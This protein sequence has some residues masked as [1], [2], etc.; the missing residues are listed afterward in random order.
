MVPALLACCCVVARAE[1]PRVSL[2][3][4]LANPHNYGMADLHLHQFGEFK[5]GGGLFGGRSYGDP[6][7]ALGECDGT[8]EQLVQ[9]GA[10][11]PPL[12]GPFGAVTNQIDALSPSQRALVEATLAMVLRENHGDDLGP[13]HRPGL[14]ADPTRRN[15]TGWPTS[16]SIAHTQTWTGWLRLAHEGPAFV[17][18]V[19]DHF[20][21]PT[22]NIVG[23]DLQA[24]L[25][26][27]LVDFRGPGYA[28]NLAAARAD[29]FVGLD[30]IV[31]SAVHIR[32][33]CNVVFEPTLRARAAPQV[34]NGHSVTA[35]EGGT[36]PA[37]ER[38]VESSPPSSWTFCDD[39]RAVPAI[40]RH[41]T[42]WARQQRDW[43]A[44][45]TS[46]EEAWEIIQ[47]GRLAV[48][49]SM[50]VEDVLADP[51]EEPEDLLDDVFGEGLRTLTIAH[52]I[53]SRYA[54][55]A[56]WSPALIG[57]LQGLREDYPY[58]IDPSVPRYPHKRE[59]RLNSFERSVHRALRNNL[60]DLLLL[61]FRVSKVASFRDR[62][63][64]MS[65]FTDVAHYAM[66]DGVPVGPP[67]NSV[68]LTPDGRNLIMQMVRR[69]MPIDV[70]HLSRAAVREIDLLL[71]QRVD[72][73]DDRFPLYASHAHVA[74]LEVDAHTDY[75]LSSDVLEIL[76]RR[77]GVVGLRPSDDLLHG[78]D[79]PFARAL[80]DFDCRRTSVS[81]AAS[82]H[83][84]QRDFGQT[85]EAPGIRLAWGTDLT[86]FI[87]MASRL[88]G[89]LPGSAQPRTPQ[90]AAAVRERLRQRGEPWAFC[91][92]AGVS[93]LP[94]SEF[95]GR[96]LAHVGLVPGMMDEVE[97]LL[98]V[99]ETGR[100]AAAG[101][102]RGAWSF[103]ELWYRARTFADG[104]PVRAAHVPSPL[105]PAEPRD[106]Y[107]RPVTELPVARYVGDRSARPI[108]TTLL[109]AIE[110][111]LPYADAPLP[112]VVSDAPVRDRSFA[113]QPPT[114]AAQLLMTGYRLED[115]AAWRHDVERYV[116]AIG[117]PAAQ[118]PHEV[119][120]AAGELFQSILRACP[121]AT[122]AC[123][124]SAPCRDAPSIGTST[125][126]AQELDQLAATGMAGV[127]LSHCLQ[128]VWP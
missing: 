13:H 106:T 104:A 38:M 48:V 96:G 62:Q 79:T 2:Q 57:V 46:P 102:R 67:E 19:L 17:H 78:V 73:G 11:A 50:E 69:G 20:A 100:A 59:R 119:D 56:N 116:E 91:E 47:S 77:G 92:L 36:A 44:I 122:E 51:S 109:R 33:V 71:A 114:L 12:F 60:F 16:D 6:L 21:A 75:H 82:A 83:L 80:D 30:L 90:G 58:P 18:Y 117:D 61:G 9:I 76:A 45:A 99:D 115:S 49:L 14:T 41:T 88:T 81:V 111:W 40:L 110:S 22:G 127:A 10:S 126:P 53:D 68:G 124:A 39:D 35:R 120:A 7:D 32:P 5:F 87:N 118:L 55:A 125:D 42:D 89:R 70:T 128:A 112:G 24:A 86:G 4:S 84:L 27:L 113:W 63:A 54:G 97:R 98:H 93:Q 66:L 65:T 107:T 123:A 15:W 3:E 95:A 74:S 121:A 34:W 105:D 64:G 31:S 1:A 23:S 28:E 52:E 94:A 101:L 43:A 103:V 85:S 108:D 25:P 29:G 8:D 37:R 26:G 72:R